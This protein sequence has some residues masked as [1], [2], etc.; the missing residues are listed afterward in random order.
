MRM[1]RILLSSG[2]TIFSHT[3]SQTV[4]F[5]GKYAIEHKTC[6]VL[7]YRFVWN[8]SHSNKKSVSY[9]HKSTRLNARFLCNLSFL[10]RF[11]KNLQ[12]SSFKKICRVGAELFLA[13]RR[14]VGER[15]RSY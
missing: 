9:H 15:W 5:T 2:S 7:L 13:D 10:A 11:S 4:R 12:M 3:I 8:F 1:R 14:T 6:F